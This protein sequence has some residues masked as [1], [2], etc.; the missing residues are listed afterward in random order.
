MKQIKF[1]SYELKK[2]VTTVTCMADKTKFV[3]EFD[4]KLN[5]QYIVSESCNKFATVFF[6]CCFDMTFKYVN[7]LKIYV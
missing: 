3:Q 7:R 1:K 4:I 6:F 5:F 2:N